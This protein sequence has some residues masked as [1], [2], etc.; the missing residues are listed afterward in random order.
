VIPSSFRSLRALR[1]LNVLAVGLALATVT[2]M[3]F[4]HLAGH[5]TFGCA[6]F[7]TGLP[8]LLVGTAWARLL[9]WRATVGRTKLRWGWLLSV[10][11]AMINAG[12]AAGILMSQ[13]GSDAGP[14]AFLGGF[15]LGVTVGAM[16]WLPA[17]ILTLFLFGLPIAWAEKLADRGLAGEERGEWVIGLTSSAL[18]LAGLLGIANY[19]PLWEKTILPRHPY[20]GHLGLASLLSTENLNTEGLALMA[21]MGVLG[22]AAGATATALAGAREHRR[23]RFVQDAEA[24]K[25]PGYRVDATPEGKVLVR[26]ASPDEH[27]RAAESDEELFALDEE[28]LARA[29]LRIAG[30]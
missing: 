20:T 13:Q 28:G 3:I 4:G 22:L 30:E 16:V 10:P 19:Y 8:T 15:A 14:V 29:P 24:G 11:L 25:L 27:Y 1:R 6:A 12:L 7:V 18:S 2:S 17:L 23:R 9:R 5:E 26:V 21:L